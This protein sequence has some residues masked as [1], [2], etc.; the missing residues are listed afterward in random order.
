MVQA[1]IAATVIK[2]QTAR[3]DKEEKEEMN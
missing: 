2:D 1:Q 3:E